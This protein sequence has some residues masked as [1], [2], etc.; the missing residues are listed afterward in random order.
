MNALITGVA[1]FVGSHLAER[2]LDR[3]ARVTGVDCFTD[4]YARSIKESNLAV[5]AGPGRIPVRR[6]HDP[7]CGPQR[8]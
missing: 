4:Y 3:G 7:G 5:A 8:R 1:G 6:K 2:L